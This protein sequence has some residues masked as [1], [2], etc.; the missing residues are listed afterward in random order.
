MSTRKTVAVV[1]ALI[2]CLAIGIATVE[3]A[4]FKKKQIGTSITL[5]ITKT[6]ASTGPYN[7]SSPGS[8]T[9]FGSVR[10]KKPC[11]AKRNVTIFR[12]GGPVASARTGG[13]GN[14]QTT[15]SGDRGG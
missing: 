3:A 9:F 7:P 11:R 1:V 15:I 8:R 14:Y 5:G 12:N 10:A 4:K 13:S 6:S 2:A